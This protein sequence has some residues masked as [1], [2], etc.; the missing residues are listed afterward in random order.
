LEAVKG[1]GVDTLAQQARGVRLSV[2]RVDEDL[3]E[4]IALQP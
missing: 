1:F 4:T 3:L 2:M